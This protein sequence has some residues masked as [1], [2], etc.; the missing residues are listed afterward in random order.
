MKALNIHTVEKD[1]FGFIDNSWSFL[2]RV[3]V[4]PEHSMTS[5]NSLCEADRVKF[6]LDLPLCHKDKPRKNFV[7]KIELR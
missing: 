4:N 2:G 6:G 3:R 5:K 1:L 7:Q